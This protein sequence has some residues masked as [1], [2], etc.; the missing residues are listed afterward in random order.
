MALG[1][2]SVADRLPTSW[3]W[4]GLVIALG[5]VTPY[6]CFPVSAFCFCQSV[7]LG[8]LQPFL[9]QGSTFDVQPPAPVGSKLSTARV[10]RVSGE[11]PM[12]LLGSRDRFGICN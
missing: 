7:A 6:F 11:S 5:G 10:R 1:S 4:S 12:T 2:Q 3:L 9:V 8:G